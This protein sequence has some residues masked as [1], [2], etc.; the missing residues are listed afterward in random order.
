MLF[1][2]RRDAVLFAAAI[3]AFWIQLT[4][5][6]TFGIPRTSQSVR[7]FDLL[8]TAVGSGAVAP[9]QVLVEAPPGSVL[10]AADAGGHRAAGRGA[11][12]DPEVAKVYTGA[13]EAFVDAS[14]RYQQVLVA[15][16]HDYGFPQSQAF[17]RRLRGDDHP[18]RRLPGDDAA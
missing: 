17:V 3:P 4:P 7:G 2:V 14:S 13:R 16:R 8:R 11:R 6:S 12:R 18:C 15:G 9:A 5:G 10:A 1:L